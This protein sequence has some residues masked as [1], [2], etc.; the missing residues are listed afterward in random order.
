MKDKI[1]QGIKRGSELSELRG[2]IIAFKN[3]GG[4]QKYAQIILNEI[5]QDYLKINNMIS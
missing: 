5:R 2:I 4:S 3:N 1:K